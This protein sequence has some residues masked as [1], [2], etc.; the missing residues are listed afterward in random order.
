MTRQRA[1]I[2]GAVAISISAI[3][4]GLDGV[5]LTPRL[6]NLK[7]GYVVFILH[8]IP[9]VLMNFFLYKQY[10]YIKKFT[11]RDLLIIFLIALL[12][13]AIGT[14]SIVKA[15]FLVNFQNLSIVVLLQK[16][17]PIFGIALAGILLG[18]KIH[19]QFILWA[20]IA[21]SAGYFLTF[22]LSLPDLETG[23]DTVTAAL[24]ALLAAFSFGS[25]TI[26]SKMILK[27][28]TFKTATFYR[29]GTTTMIMLVYVLITGQL[30][31]F[32]VTTRQNWIFFIVIALT[33][34]SGAIFLYYY[35]LNHVK[36]IISLIVELLFPITTI[37]LD[38]FFNNNR[39]SF[40]QWISALIMVVAIISLNR[41]QARTVYKERPEVIK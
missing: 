32:Q 4:W 34:G 20:V 36:A 8:A 16:L 41:G 25:S 10:S 12:G 2:I 39:L 24:F 40:I 7:V 27:R 30:D 15:L 18:E 31:Q 28:Y 5:V 35:G 37:L 22:G 3:L 38:Y 11:R 17:Q 14:L 1:A 33:T 9:F 29:Y 13:G 23:S 21:I 26:F 6:Y 19:K